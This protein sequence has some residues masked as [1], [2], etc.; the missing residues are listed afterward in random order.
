MPQAT[1]TGLFVS[2]CTIQQP[3]I[4]LDAAG[5]PLY[6]PPTNV[7][8]MVDIPC[9]DEPPGMRIQATEVKALAEI[10]AKLMR[11]VLLSGYYP[12]VI[13]SMWAVVDG[14]TYDI[15]GAESDSQNQQTRLEL[16]IATV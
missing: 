2:L 16:Q 14:V 12:L 8:G 1:A 6:N 15:L 9:M 13:P 7:P 5:A 10:G 4:T 3:N 11:H